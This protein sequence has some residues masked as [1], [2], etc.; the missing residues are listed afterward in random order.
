LIE[1]T[2]KASRVS[3]LA[4]GISTCIV[5]PARF[6]PAKHLPGIAGA[7]FACI[8]VNCA[9][10]EDDFAWESPGAWRELASV[11]ADLGV[12][13][14]A[15]HTPTKLCPEDE[16]TRNGRER[17]L[18]ILKKSADFAADVGA[19]VVVI[20][21][22][23]PRRIDSAAGDTYLR[24]LLDELAEYF[25]PLPCVIG[26]EN[27]RRSFP[28]AK[29]LEWVRSFGPSSMGQHLCGL[30]L[31]DNDG[32]QDQHTVPGRGNVDWESFMKSLVAAGYTGPLML[33]IV[34]RHAPDELPNLLGACMDS[35][36]NLTE[37]ASMNS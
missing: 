32:K 10:G 17:T 25:L 18:D 27:D 5:R 35:A 34:G 11:S 15:V 23:P 28:P 26:W 9:M 3:P 2:K 6:E 22:R 36:R 33:E 13:V 1:Q 4:P 21:A 19:H 29:L 8:E 12:Q 14:H 37:Y 7:G 24:N 20:H 31:S 30:H 16:G